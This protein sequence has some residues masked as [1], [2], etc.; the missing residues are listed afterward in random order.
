MIPGA[1]YTYFYTSAPPNSRVPDCGMSAI[2]DGL[3][4]YAARS[5]H[6]GGVNAAMADGSIRWFT[7]GTNVTMWRSLGTRAGQEIAE[8]G[9]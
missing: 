7:S 6:P 8:L 4:I 2:N 3:G 9:P 5:Y 1:I